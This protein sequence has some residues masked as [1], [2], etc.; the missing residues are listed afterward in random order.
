[1]SMS[2]DIQEIKLDMF[3]SIGTCRSLLLRGEPLTAE[4]RAVLVG[5]LNVLEEMVETARVGKAG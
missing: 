4:D 2:D 5:V 3:R 1:M